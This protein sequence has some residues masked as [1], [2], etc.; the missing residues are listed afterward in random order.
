MKG[1]VILFSALLAGIA[2][3]GERPIR[4]LQ[5]DLA[6]Q[7]ETAAGRGQTPVVGM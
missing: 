2:G 3:A 6:R 1:K 7:K 4:A 5:L